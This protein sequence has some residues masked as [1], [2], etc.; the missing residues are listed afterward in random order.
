MKMIGILLAGLF[1]V[2]M[3]VFGGCLPE[4]SAPVAAAA[5]EKS[6]TVQP[7]P[8]PAAEAAATLDEGV[9]VKV[10]DSVL[11]KA[12]VEAQKKY[13]IPAYVKLPEITDRWI[14]TA[15]MTQEAK[16]RGMDKD[17][18]IKMVLDAISDQVL[19][20][21][22]VKQEQSNVVIDEADAKEFYEKNQDNRMFRAADI[23]T[24]EVI[25]TKT[26]QQAEEILAA[27]NDNETWQDLVKANEQQTC[28]IT[29]LSSATVKEMTSD[30]LSN[31]GGRDLR[32]NVMR[33]ARTLN[34]ITKPAR[35][36]KG[37]TLTKVSEKKSGGIKPFE[38]VKDRIK[39]TLAQKK[40]S[41]VGENL[42]ATLKLQA[43]II[44]SPE[45]LEA[46]KATG[47]PAKP[48]TA[49]RAKPAPK[50]EKPVTKPAEK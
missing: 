30:E 37:W 41:L 7:E 5:P 45:L 17:E 12:L 46:E 23:L 21:I 47:K 35:L 8:Q 15:L 39:Q 42:V 3:V 31:I 49:N 44:K 26:K 4:K 34:T 38:Q 22:L 11:T 28:K 29:G 18:E 13:F 33:A 10:N 24:F 50:P 1:V 43:T 36:R 19:A 20:S 14:E 48:R 9:L 32:R 2:S 16:R 27:M 6:A 40:K 25:V